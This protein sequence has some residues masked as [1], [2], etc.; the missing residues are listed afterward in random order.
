MG[1]DPVAQ[2]RTA[3]ER[4]AWS[5]AFALLT[6]ADRRKPL[7]PE[8]L[9]RLAT[10]AYLIGDDGA[11]NDARMR[12]HSAFLARGAIDRAAR[13]AFWLAFVALD[14]PDQQTTAN[15]WL[16]RVRRLLDQC[17]PDCA[18]RGFWLCASGFQK[19]SAGDIEGARAEF[20]EAARL[21]SV[22]H[23]ADLTTLA[24]QAQARILLRSNRAREGLAALDEL[25]V[26]VACGEVGPLITGLVYCSVIGACHE[27]FDLRR[28]QEWTAALAGWCDAHPDMTPFRGPCL[29][30]RSELLQLHGAWDASMQEAA[31]ACEGAER[32]AARSSAGAAWYQLGELHRLR[33]AFE[34]ADV[35]YRRAALAGRQPEPGRA[36][37]KLAQGQTSAAVAAVDRALAE[38]KSPRARVDILRASVAVRL[39]TGDSEGARGVASELTRLT[40]QY[41]SPYLDAV[42]AAASGALALAAG[43]DEAALT[44]LRSAAGL[45]RQVNAPY[46]LAIVHAK[47]GSVYEERGDE[48]GARMEYEAAQEIFEQLG[49]APD[50]ARMT[51]RLGRWT[52]RAAGGLTGRE[53]EVLRLLA[54]GKS[55]RAIG[56]ALAIS[57]KTVAR[58][59]SNI[60]TKLDL[61]SRSAATAYAY[62]HRLI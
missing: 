43:Q 15:G 53:V 19:I 34:E 56:T 14:K 61:S 12:A 51:E 2:G 11:S 40:Q 24:R 49:A 4:E 6:A 30:R 16:A 20:D 39:E 9:E 29:V 22:C 37:L 3:F 58:H 33:G 10:A 17:P 36:L 60:F 28:A 25:I 8:D 35:A 46:E 57:E 54:T 32:A 5:E 55:N 41:Q 47:L 23:D 48:D 13:N 1:T 42:N 31:R 27:V 59:I 45:W 44:T 21:G 38:V 7:D 18:E 50:A 52:R 62:E 26:A